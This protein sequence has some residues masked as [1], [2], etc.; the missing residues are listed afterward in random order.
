[1][2]VPEQ[3]M[4][5]FY[6]SYRTFVLNCQEAISDF[7]SFTGFHTK[8]NHILKTGQISITLP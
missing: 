8:R 1:M 4:G 5:L 6:N 3:A 2:Q 7:V